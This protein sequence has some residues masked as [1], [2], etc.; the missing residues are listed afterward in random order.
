MK[1]IWKNTPFIWDDMAQQAFENIELAM[2][3]QPILHHFEPT[4]PLTLETDAS[5]YAIGAVCLQ[6]DQEG[7]LHPLGYFSQKLKDAE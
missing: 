5:D 7:V 2:V 1:L 3:S 4:Y 6:P